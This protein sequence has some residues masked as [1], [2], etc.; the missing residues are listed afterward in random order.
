M[1]KKVLIASI[2][3]ATVVIGSGAAVWN[4]KEDSALAKKPGAV[5]PKQAM[6]RYS[7]P[8]HKNTTAAVV[9]DSRLNQQN[10]VA[11]AANVLNV[12]PIDIIKE[13][14]KG[15]TL[16]QVAK[17]KGLTETEFNK[18]LTDF[19]SK[20]VDKAVK[21]GTITKE[22]GDA[23]KAGRTDR[24]KNGMKEKAMKAHTAMDMG[25]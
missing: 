11:E 10:I 16:V 6:A 13:M 8:S 5:D 21:D 3:A 2:L 22:H 19:D 17:D 15:K 14:D 4:S 9:R 20:I 1:G 24:I 23:I 25:N 12:L 18:K 7:P